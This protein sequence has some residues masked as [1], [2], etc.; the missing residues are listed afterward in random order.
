MRMLLI[1]LCLFVT[2]A[3]MHSRAQAN[4]FIVLKKN[5]RTL[6]SLFAGSLAEF[7]TDR[8]YYAGRITSIL[9]DSI[10]LVEYDVRQVPTHLGVYVLDTVAF[11]R[12]KFNYHEITYMGK[13]ADKGFNWSGSGGSLFGGGLLLT[14]VGLGTWIFFKPGT[15]YHAP[16][17]L[18]LA[19]AVLGGVGYLLMKKG[20]G[21][22]IGNKYSLEYIETK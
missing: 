18:I 3:P 1:F 20:S 22:K 5:G 8:G 17:S 12:L 2:L 4:D 21:Y 7:T 16:A 11:Y 15:T 19:S 6:T 10:F 13:K 9:H 14:T